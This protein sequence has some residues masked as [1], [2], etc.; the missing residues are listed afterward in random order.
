MQNSPS[1]KNG[2]ARLF[3]VELDKNLKYEDLKQIKRRL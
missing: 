3:Q 2:V 1:S